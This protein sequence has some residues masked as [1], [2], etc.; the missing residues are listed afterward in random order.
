E[1]E[2]ECVRRGGLAALREHR[3]RGAVEGVPHRLL[4]PVEVRDSR[5]RPRIALQGRIVVLVRVRMEAELVHQRLGPL[6]RAV[7]D[8]EVVEEANGRGRDVVLRERVVV[9]ARR[10]ADTDRSEE[11]RVGKECKYRG[12][13]NGERKK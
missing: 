10:Q 11:R 3:L 2:L 13:L 9:P 4:D 12:W 8:A 5:L 6:A 1:V 7:G